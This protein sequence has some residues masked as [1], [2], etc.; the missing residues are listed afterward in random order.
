MK[1]QIFFLPEIFLDLY[2]MKIHI[3]FCRVSIC[4]PNPQYMGSGPNDLN[5]MNL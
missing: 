4:G 5:T 2:L 1:I 3:C